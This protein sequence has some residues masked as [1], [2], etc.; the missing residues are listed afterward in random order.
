M[1]KT[2]QVFLLSLLVIVNVS[3][4]FGQTAEEQKKKWGGNAQRDCVKN[5]NCP[6]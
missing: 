4:A 2:I 3:A 6:K 1:R 5:G